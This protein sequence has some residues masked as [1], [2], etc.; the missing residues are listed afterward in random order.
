MRVLGLGERPVAFANRLL[1]LRAELALGALRAQ[2]HAVADTLVERPPV[3]L[4][5]LA[6]TRL[7]PALGADQRLVGHQAE[8]T[9]AGE[10][11]GAALPPPPA[12]DVALERPLADRGDPGGEQRGLHC[13]N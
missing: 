7:P 6:L 12:R 9:T 1:G 11:V 5:V 3:V 2:G 10:V 13:L 8:A 4:G